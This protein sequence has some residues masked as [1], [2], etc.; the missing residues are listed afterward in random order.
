METETSQLLIWGQFILDA[1]LISALVG[2]AIAWKVSLL[3]VTRSAEFRESVA[4]AVEAKIHTLTA[5]C[6]A[7]ENSWRDWHEKHQRVAQ[8][9]NKVEGIARAKAEG[10]PGT[11]EEVFSIS[12]PPVDRE[13][14]PLGELTTESPEHERDAARAKITREIHFGRKSG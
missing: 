11:E 1:V 12:G 14:K 4:A 6:E 10:R 2:L 5:R 7:L 13:G 3:T 9:L 8:R